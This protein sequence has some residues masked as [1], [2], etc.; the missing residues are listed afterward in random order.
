MM[1]PFP[2]GDAFHPKTSQNAQGEVIPALKLIYDPKTHDS[3]I[4]KI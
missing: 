3:F 1:F 2:I 4:P